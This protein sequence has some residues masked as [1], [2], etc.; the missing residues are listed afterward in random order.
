M[1]AVRG[2]TRLLQVAAEPSYG[3]MAT[4]RPQLVAIGSETG[5]NQPGST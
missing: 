3:I 5:Q 1:P 2:D 4:I